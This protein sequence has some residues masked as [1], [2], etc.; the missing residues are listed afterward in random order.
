MGLGKTIQA[1]AAAP[2]GHPLLVIC[3]NVLKGTWI[4]EAAKWR[5]EIAKVTRLQGRGSF[6][7][8][9]PGEL[10]ILNYDI[11]PETDAESGGVPHGCT[12]GTT[13]IFDEAHALKNHKAKRTQRSRALANEVRSKDGRTW[14]MT[15]TPLLNDPSELW[16]VLQ[17]IGCAQ[18]AFGSYNA[19]FD[20]MGGSLDKW[21]GV[22]WSSCPDE[23]I[24]SR[25]R[26]VSLRRE[27]AEVLPELP[28]KTFREIVVPIDRK[29]KTMLDKAWKVL[30]AAGIDLESAEALA[31][32]SKDAAIEL[33]TVS[34]ARAALATAKIPSLLEL[35]ESYEE[36]GEPLVVF[37]RHRAP[38]DA[39]ASRPG[40]AT[41]T[42]DNSK[43][44]QAVAELF[45]AGKLKGVAATIQAG[46][47]GITLTRATQIVLVDRDWT[48]ALNDQ[49][50][51]RGHRIGLQHG[52]LI[53]DL[54]ADHAMDA[55]VTKVLKKKQAIIS[56]TIAASTIGATEKPVDD[57]TFSDDELRSLFAET[58]MDSQ[59]P[60][61]EFRLPQGA[62][63]DWAAR[64][65]LFLSDMDPDAAFELNDVGWNKLD[66]TVG[67]SLATSFVQHDGKMTDKQYQ[68]AIRLCC[69]YHRQVG[70]CPATTA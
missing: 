3:P 14:G 31:A 50:I 16:A 39:L 35:V 10:V 12:A 18:E 27:K 61:K 1:L 29:T 2:E 47:V 38:I 53:T 15:A 54:V 70:P 42:G 9:A 22:R 43:D 56:R 52:L 69:K 46:G 62:Q 21:G 67:H 63:E 17:A 49:A 32:A 59:S 28:E 6:R 4:A 30:Q 51:D 23:S 48:P 58:V 11:L 57:Q 20:M 36:Q 8:P 44:A 7:W 68:L 33:Q 13:L 64:A 37:S 60:G 5:P 65:I 45:Q 26:R 19:F 55:H 40:W 34:A 66:G 41:I 25:I 24:P